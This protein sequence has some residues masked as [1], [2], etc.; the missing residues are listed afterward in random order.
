MGLR[1]FFSLTPFLPI[2]HADGIWTTPSVREFTTVYN[3]L[4]QITSNTVNSQ[5]WF[6]SDTRDFTYAHDLAYGNVIRIGPEGE[7]YV[8]GM[9]R[10]A[11]IVTPGYAQSKRGT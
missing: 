2:A 9:P 3:E 4:D 8:V 5:E 7:G 11:R 6:P 10:M 1:E